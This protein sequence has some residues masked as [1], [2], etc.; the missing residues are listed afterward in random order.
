VLIFA[1][2]GIEPPTPIVPTATIAQV[3]GDG[4]VSPFVGRC[5]GGAEGVVTA[6]LGSRSG[7]AFWLQDPVGDDDPDTSEGLLVMAPAGLPQ[8][9]IGDRA[10]LAGRVEERRW[11]RELPVTRL[12]ATTLEVVEQGSELPAPVVLGDGGLVVPQPEVAAPDLAVF[13][14][15]RY[16]ADAFESVEGMRVVIPDPVAVGPTSRHGEAA[17]LPDGGRS[18]AL[19]T[20]RGGLRLL[21]GNA[22]PQRLVVDDAIVDQPRRFTVGDLLGGPIDGILHYSYGSYKVLNTAPLPIVADGGLEPER[23]E[24]VGRGGE[25]TVATYNVENLSAVSEPERF[26]RLAAVVVGGLASPDIVALQEVQDDSGPADDGTV[27]ADATLGRIVDA[28]EMAGGPRYEWHSVAPVDG[29]SGGQPGGNIRNAFLVNPRR[30]T[31]VER[32][33][34]DAREE[35]AAHDRLGVTC[36]PGLIAT[37]H[38]AFTPGPL[39]DGG[40]RK[41]LVGLFRFAGRELYLVNLHLASKGGDDRLFGW[42]QPPVAV[43]SE[44]RSRQAEA[45]ADFVVALRA[46]DA[47]ASVVVLGDLNDFEGSQPLAVLEAVGLEDLIRR[48]PAGDRYTYVYRGNSQVLDHILVSRDLGVAAEVDAVHVNAE[49]PA[50]TRASDHDPVLVR[51]SFER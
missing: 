14:P 4:H 16:A 24:L 38:P 47:G 3:Q 18:A 42:R 26:Q 45:V 37:D 48:V 49:F 12:F 11:A 41:P 29:T 35:T 36:S 43:T 34:C 19:R 13:D 51:F 10:R 15:A 50:A 22:N 27:S 31:F 21:P 8:V 46:A 6:I 25:L 44:L 1:A 9:A 39:D 7:Q 32:G 28:V 20:D 23:T 40:S 2:S 33:D 30:V 17:V 5:V